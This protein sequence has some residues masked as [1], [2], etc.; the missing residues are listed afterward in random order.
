[1]LKG[2]ATRSAAATERALFEEGWI[3]RRGNARRRMSVRSDG[4]A[5]LF[6]AWFDYGE[7]N[8]PSDPT[9]TGGLG[10]VLASTRRPVVLG[11]VPRVLL[12]EAIRSLEVCLAQAGAGKTHSRSP[13]GD[14]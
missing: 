6:L 5:P 10:F 1:M 13:A 9:R 2:R 7:F 3:P 12:S 4:A 8:A 11:D 14:E